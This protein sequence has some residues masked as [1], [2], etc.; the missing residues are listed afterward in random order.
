MPRAQ[1]TGPKS[2]FIYTRDNGTD[3]IV[4]KM[5]PDLVA[6]NSGLQIATPAL[7][8]AASPAPKG[9]KPRGVYWQGTDDT[10]ENSR[11]FL[12]CG[13][14]ASALYVAD[15]PT[16]VTIDTVAGITTG[17]RGEKQSFI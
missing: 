12:V 2:K 13:T 8:A 4:M 14:V 6:A 16:V 11:K 10:Y 17:K 1:F 5:D 7:I 3:T 9:F 15:S